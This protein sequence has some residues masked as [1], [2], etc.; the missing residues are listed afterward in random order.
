MDS[1]NPRCIERPDA[2]IPGINRMQPA[3]I[4]SLDVCDYYNVWKERNRLTL[5]LS[6][7]ENTDC[8]K[9]NIK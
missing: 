4:M 6:A 2:L 3:M 9:K 8:M 7:A 5:E 1:R